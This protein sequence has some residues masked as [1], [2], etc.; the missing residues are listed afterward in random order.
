[1]ARVKYDYFVSNERRRS[2]DIIGPY[3]LAD[4]YGE[5]NLMNS[6]IDTNGNLVKNIRREDLQPFQTPYVFVIK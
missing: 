5:R 2:L 4:F 1:M 3:Y 6:F